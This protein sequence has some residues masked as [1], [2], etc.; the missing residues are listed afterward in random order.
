MTRRSRLRTKDNKSRRLKKVLAVVFVTGL[1]AWVCFSYRQ[2]LQTLAE[3]W[4]ETAPVAESAEETVRGT[5]YDRNFKEL[6]YTMERVSLYAR[7]RE[8]TDLS[9]TVGTLSELLG[10]PE[11]EC[12]TSLS[13]DS[14]MVWLLRDLGQE[15]EDRIRD[16]ALPGI[17]L[18]REQVRTYPGQS[19][20][21]HIV[22]YAEND[23]GLAGVEHFY[24]TPLTHSSVRQEDFPRI[25]FKGEGATAGSGHDLVLTV[26]LKIENVLDQYLQKMGKSM[27]GAQIAAVLMEAD[28]GKIVGGANYPSYNPNGIWQYEKGVLEDLLFTPMVVPDE[29][30]E[31]FMEASL[32]Q[33]VWEQSTQV[34][35]W[36]VVN[37]TVS[38]PRQLRLWERLQL[39]TP[40]QVD[41]TAGERQD[42]SVPEFTSCQPVRDVGTVPRVLSPL[43]VLL[44]FTQ[45][46]N[47]GKRIQPHF[48]D[49]I[50]VQPSQKEYHYNAFRLN[51]DGMSVLPAL[52]SEELQKSV[53]LSGVRGL[54]GSVSISGET[55]SWMKRKG[56]DQEYVRD[57]ISLTLIPAEKPELVLLLAARQ[58]LLGPQRVDDS[59]PG[60]LSAAIDS[61]LPSMVALQQVHSNFAGLLEVEERKDSNFQAG[62][63]SKVDRGKTLAGML[64]EEIHLMPDLTGMSL[65]QGL[66]LLEKSDLKI[67]VEGSGRIVAQK[68]KVGKLLEKGSR[69]LLVL[70]KDSDPQDIV[71]VQ[72]MQK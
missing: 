2:Q 37:G 40:D 21:A 71:P 50:L 70:K 53:Y 45:L 39:T 22:G 3:V 66:R 29:L 51:S 15:D 60:Y 34:Y 57:R 9:G 5:I 10:I 67:R 56:G 11:T 6:A 16:A 26:D 41:V 55:V 47:G 27:A 19:V 42:M 31:V 54:L 65:R 32:L 28:T 52:V 36:S 30:R 69:C 8:V 4:R 1:I 25:D 62:Q 38:Y 61:V 13:K 23:V 48:L 14:H 33:G 17:Y 63:K 68:P 12:L 49:R 44:G 18:H 43:K 20:G 64:D 7:P 35:P 72:H 46:V 24:N 59:K 58:K